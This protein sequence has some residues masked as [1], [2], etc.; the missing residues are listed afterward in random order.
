[1]SDLPREFI[2]DHLDVDLLAHVIPDG[3]HKVLINPWLELA[4]PAEYVSAGFLRAM[5]W[6]VNAHDR[7]G[8]L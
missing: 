1:M 7:W 2:A 6:L 8:S 5:K 3:A 4:H